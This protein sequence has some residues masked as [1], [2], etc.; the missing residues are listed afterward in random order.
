[1]PSVVRNG[2]VLGIHAPT[3]VVVHSAPLVLPICA[4]PIRDGA[5]AIRGNRVLQVGVRAALLASFPV[6]EEV[7]WPGL[8][9]A[10]LIDACA[11][12]AAPAPGVTATATV[13]PD[14]SDPAALPGV[15][16]IEVSCPS[17][18]LWE[19]SGRD[20]L[21]T[22][23]REVDQ[24]CTIGIAA[25][26]GDPQVLEDLAVLARTFGLRVLVDLARHSPAVLDEAGM[27]GPHAHVACAG[28]LDPGERKLLRLR[29]TVVA[30]CPAIRPDDALALI[31]EGNLVALGTRGGGDL[32]GQAR[33]IR[34]HA[35][36]RS[37]RTPGLDRKLVEAAT[38]GGARALGLS[39]G[40][41]R[42]GSLSPGARADLAIFDVRG[43][44]PYS[45]LLGEA[46]CIGTVTG[47]VVRPGRS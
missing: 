5:V 13:A 33:A 21:I 30:V 28:H 39:A 3:L 25:Y 10:G 46:P 9:V 15:T 11:A 17:E 47:G 42:I 45:A 19:E 26:T 24:P 38:I 31:D 27:L 35:R 41:G 7:R 36:S 22:A 37:P 20:T 16:Y 23:I 29:K 40:A 6:V 8:I 14:L 34:A 43:R 1:M 18:E 44:Y 2:Q 32:L 4:E 12:S